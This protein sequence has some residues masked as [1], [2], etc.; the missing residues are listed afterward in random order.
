MPNHDE[1]IL[2]ARRLDTGAPWPLHHQALRVALHGE[3]AARSFHTRVIEAFGPRAPFPAALRAAESRIARLT[4]L[5]RRG[6]V[7]CP[8][9]PYPQE[10]RIAASWRENCLRA[11]QGE[12]TTAATYAQLLTRVSSPALRD[13][14][15]RLQRETIAKRLPAFEEA[16]LRA[17]ERERLHAAQGVAP[18]DAY[19][20]HGPVANFLERAFS[21]LGQQH[22]AFNVVGPLLRNTGP[23]LLAGLVAGTTGTYFLKRKIRRRS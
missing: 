5:C 9:D 19:I 3:Y 4:T 6:G 15:A 12:A 13:A 14:F 18:A 8:H 17:F 2:R 21:V 16:A 22:Q 23:A 10:T 11:Y 7:P 20:E 1:A